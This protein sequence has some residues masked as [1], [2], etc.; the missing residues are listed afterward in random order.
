VVFIGAFPWWGL[1]AEV[2][3][4]C[5]RTALLV[6][7]SPAWQGGAASPFINLKALFMI[8][9]E[10]PCQPACFTA[11]PPAPPALATLPPRSTFA[12]EPGAQLTLDF[13]S[14]VA[15]FFLGPKTEAGSERPGGLSRPSGES[16]RA[17]SPSVLA[18][19]APVF[20]CPLIKGRRARSGGPCKGP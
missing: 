8:R 5:S 20:G 18:V 9:L 19:Q 4:C 15:E 14:W 17:L 12:N 6:G 10:S 1:T 7:L 3:V 13:Q 16:S 2:P 11:W